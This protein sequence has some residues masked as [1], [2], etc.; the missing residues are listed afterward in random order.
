M[1]Y[2]IREEEKPGVMIH[3]NR[4][5][6]VLGPFGTREEALEEAK[7]HGISTWILLQSVAVTS[8]AFTLDL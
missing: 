2:L 7:K 3:G 4:Y 5:R 6:L 1:Y 8:V